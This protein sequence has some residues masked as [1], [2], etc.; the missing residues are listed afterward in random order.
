MMT[1]KQIITGIA[2]ECVR[3]FNG[4]LYKLGEE[5]EIKAVRLYQW[6][7][8]PSINLSL[9]IIHHLRPEVFLDMLKRVL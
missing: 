5:M 9:D 7:K 2:L 1:P 3:E 8:E 4:S 6:K